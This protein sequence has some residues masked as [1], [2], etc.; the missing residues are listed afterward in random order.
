MHPM[1]TT[2]F[3]EELTALLRRTESRCATPAKG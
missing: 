1:H 3:G 2:D